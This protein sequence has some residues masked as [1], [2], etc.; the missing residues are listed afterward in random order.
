VSTFI[1]IVSCSFFIVVL[2]IVCYDET[3]HV[4]WDVINGSLHIYLFFKENIYLFKLLIKQVDINL[5]FFS[6][7]PN[8]NSCGT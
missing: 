7:G 2:L 3:Y 6:Y 1:F 4:H 8:K 5:G